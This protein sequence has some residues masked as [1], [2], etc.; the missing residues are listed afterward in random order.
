MSRPAHNKLTHDQVVAYC[1]QTG[2]KLI[3]PEYISN[4]YKHQW[5]CG[6]CGKIVSQRLDK[7]KRA[8][9][10]LNCCSRVSENNVNHGKRIADKWGLIFK[11][12]SFKNTQIA[13]E[14]ECPVHGVFEYTL[15]NALHTKNVNPCKQCRKDLEDTQLESELASLYKEVPFIKL[16]DPEYKGKRVSHRWKCE[17]HNYETSSNLRL[18]L[19]NKR[20]KCCRAKELSGK[21]HPLYNPYIDESQRVKKRHYG[22]AQVWSK[23]VRT[24]D[25]WECVI[26]GHN[27][28]CVAHHL[29]SYMAH[30]DKRYDVDN[31]VTLCRPHHIEFHQEYGIKLNT[32]EQF[33]EYKKKKGA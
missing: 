19:K 29:D 2:I 28:K 20:L 8:N 14:W 10:K 18:I 31:G 22:A 16:L 4:S 26:C 6:R 5:E 33:N 11:E 25:K 32:K 12:L 27:S 23:A 13:S 1:G 3:D 15:F 17:K 24:R 21:N 30:P 7:I 9:G